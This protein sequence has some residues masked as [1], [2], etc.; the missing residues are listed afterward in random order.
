MRTGK[1]AVEGVLVIKE[2]TGEWPVYPGHPLVLAMAIMEVYPSY[3]LANATTE[4]GWC[5]ALG[6]CRIPGAGCHVSAA[7]RTLKLGAEGAGIDE[8]VAYAHSYWEEGRAGGHHKNIEAG[9]AQAEE[10]L[11]RFRELASRWFEQPPKARHEA[12]QEKQ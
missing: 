10:A 11:P 8:M 12:Q 1:P 5:E 9:R 2:R 6:D 7:M 3:E 4:H